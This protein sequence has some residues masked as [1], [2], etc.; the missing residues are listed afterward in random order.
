MLPWNYPYIAVILLMVLIYAALEDLRKRKITTITFLALDVLLF[1][2]FV[3]FNF[4]LALFIIPIVSEYFL[5]RFSFVSYALL[6]VPLYFEMSILTVSIAYS[7]LLV[8][9]FGVIIKNFGRGDVKVLQT[10]AVTLPFYPHL[11]LLDSLFPPVMAV[12]LMASLMGTVSSFIFAKSK[13]VGNKTLGSPGSS[14]STQLNTS[15]YWVK[16]SKVAYKIPLVSFICAA[17]ALILILSSLRL[18]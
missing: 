6:I 12:V 9:T 10:L 15:K 3:F 5:E 18:V 8:K 1:F 17:Y 2:Y 16:G 4:W 7:I 13:Y 11:P 14:D